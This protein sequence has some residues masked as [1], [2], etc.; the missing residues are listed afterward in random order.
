MKKLALFSILG[1]ALMLSLSQCFNRTATQS[2]KP[3]KDPGL[4]THKEAIDTLLADSTAPLKNLVYLPIKGRNSYDFFKQKD[5][6]SLFKNDYPN[7]GFFGEDHYR[8]EFIFTEVKKDTFNVNVYHVKGKNRH[9]KVITPFEGTIRVTE[10]VEIID[11]NLDTASIN[12]MGVAKV[13]GAKG[14]FELNED[15]KMA[16]TS[17]KFAGNVTFEFN[18]QQDGTGPFLWFYSTQL[19]SGGSGYRFDGNWTM[20]KN[21]TVVK[22]VIWAQ[23]LFSFANNIL[24]DFSIGERDVEINEQYRHL[25][26][27]EF[28]SGE[29]WWNSG[30]KKKEM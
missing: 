10:L 6:S 24:K 19:P 17:G 26:W 3:A 2:T 23:D 30:G 13:Y 28:W 11:P 15:P 12:A 8:I 16:E 5:L 7:N 20:Y 21:S 1:I 4:I 27:D 14:V 29:E 18:E 9:K 25:G 22:P